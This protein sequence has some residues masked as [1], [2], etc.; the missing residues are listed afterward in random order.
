ME[1]LGY[2]VYLIFCVAIAMVGYQI[3]SSVF[4]AIVDFFFSPLALIKWLV[5]HEIN[6]SIIKETFEFLLN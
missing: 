2:L 4:W 3:H 5:C 6:I 1:N